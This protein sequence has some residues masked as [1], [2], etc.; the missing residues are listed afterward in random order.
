MSQPGSTGLAGPRSGA[1][2]QQ[3][4]DEDLM[5]CLQSGNN[6]ALAILFERYRRLV[7]S[8]A[9]K[10][11]G[12][13]GEAEDAMQSVF[14][15]AY[16]LAAQFDPTRGTAKVWLL[17]FA[18]HRSMNHRR[19]LECRDFY[20]SIE[21]GDLPDEAEPLVQSPNTDQQRLL[22]EALEHLPSDQAKVIQMA[23]LEG[24]SFREIAAATGQSLGN[25][26][27]YYYRGIERLRAVVK[28][29][30]ARQRVGTEEEIFDVNA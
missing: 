22:V 24:F 16:R 28:Q 10:V 1:E 25:V 5:R 27:H 19:R 3:L 8:V 2:L 26:R 7:F 29:A 6:D 4:N 23:C 9:L 20:H 12:N 21:V 15:E 17:Q 14:L 18:Y 13:V 11:I 30:P